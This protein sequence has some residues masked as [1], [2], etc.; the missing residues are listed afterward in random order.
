MFDGPLTSTLAALIV[1]LFCIAVVQMLRRLRDR[2]R[3]SEEARRRSLSVAEPRPGPITVRGTWHDRD[4]ATWLECGGARVELRGPVC[5]VRGTDARSTWRVREPMHALRDGDDVVALG[6]MQRLAASIDG[7]SSYRASA[8]GWVLAPPAGCS[9][10]ELCALQPATC[11]RA[12]GPWRGALVLVAS[13][14]LAWFSVRLVRKPSRMMLAIPGASVARWSQA[15][16]A[17]CDDLRIGPRV[18]EP[19]NP[20]SAASITIRCQLNSEWDPPADPTN[21]AGSVIQ[22]DDDNHPSRLEF[23]ALL[24]AGK[25]LALAR[26]LLFAYGL[27]R[28]LVERARAISPT[29]SFKTS[30]IAVWIY[31]EPLPGAPGLVSVDVTIEHHSSG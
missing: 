3:A 30:D 13:G 8:G 29:P 6:Y 25:A 1:T 10:I 7:D 20:I 4:E 11:P 15:V 16:T 2:R 5:I 21:D 24:H 31:V 27:P 17:V 26:A 12:L 23:Q 19:W 14:A 18:P 28:D 22:F 9:H